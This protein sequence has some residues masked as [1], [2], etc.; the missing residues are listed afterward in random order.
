M[1]LVLLAIVSFHMK[2]QPCSKQMIW[3]T[4]KNEIRH[5]KCN[6][7]MIWHWNIKNEI[8][9]WRWIFHLYYIYVAILETTNKLSVLSAPANYGVVKIVCSSSEV[10]LW[11]MKHTMIYP[12]LGPFSEVIALYSVVWYW[13]WTCVTKGWAESSRSSHG[14]RGK[15]ISYPPAWRV[16]AFYRSLG[17]PLTVVQLLYN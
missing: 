6:K 11:T 16:C 13:R 10:V 7:Q 12:S 15:W 14:E 17:G 8:R 3:H 5:W 4:H 9:H 2:I 1:K